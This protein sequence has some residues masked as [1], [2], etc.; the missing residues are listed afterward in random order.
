MCLSSNDGTVA[1]LDRP[2]LLEIL[3]HRIGV[4]PPCTHTHTHTRTNTHTHRH[5][6]AHTHTHTH[7]HTHS[8]CAFLV[9]T[10]LLFRDELDVALLCMNKRTNS[11]CCCCCSR[12]QTE[13]Y[14]GRLEKFSNC[15]AVK[16]VLQVSQVCHMLNPAVTMGEWRSVCS[17]SAL[18]TSSSSCC[19]CCPASGLTVFVCVCVHAG[20]LCV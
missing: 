6:H 3:K 16:F 11:S 13:D 1:G 5:T 7:T 15:D 17:L 14:L 20:A 10:M 4:R 18:L 12:V 8:L 19:C 2:A 9:G